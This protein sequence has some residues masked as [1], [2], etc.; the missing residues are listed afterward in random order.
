[1]NTIKMKTGVPALFYI[2]L[3]IFTLLSN[4]AQAADIT[5][6][7]SRNPVA[8]DDSFHLVYEANSSVDEDPDFT[9]IYQHFD[10]LS[11][12]QSTNM[13]SVNGSW[14]LQKT[15][16][17]SLIA[18]DIGKITVPAIK[19]G[20]DISPA[21]QITVV[22][23]S[24]ANS[25]SPD[26]QGTIPAQIFLESS[27]DKKS[28]WVQ[29]QFIYKVR[30]FRTVSI[31]SASISEPETSDPDA[32]IHP[33]GEDKYQTTRNGI[34]YEVFER[35]YAI[36]PQKS[37]PLKINPVTFE[38]RVNPT[39]ARSIFDR[40][41]IS[42]QLKRLRSK[43]V[44]TNVKSAPTT[45]NLQDWLPS[46]QLQLVEEWSDDINNIKAGDPITRTIT[47]AA[48]G[49]TA[50]QLP[51]LSFNDIDNLKQYPDKAAVEDRPTPSGITGLKQIKVALI[52]A[53]AGNYTL[54]EIKLEWWNTQ[55][56]KN[57]IA[58]LPP[59]TLTVTGTVTNMNHALP[60]T[61]KNEQPPKETVPAETVAT[62]TISSA[63][64]YWKWLSLF[65]AIAWAITL[66]LFFKRPNT[67]NK[68]TKSK[69][70]SNRVS[71]KAAASLV[72]QHAKT[73]NA[74]KTKNALIT[75]AQI[76]YSNKSITNLTLI[77]ELCSP[78]LAESIK[79]L[80]HDLYS[81]D[82]SSWHGSNLLTAFNNE[83]RSN[84]T[85]PDTHASPLKPL[86]NK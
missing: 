8:L 6:T 5:V 68:P 58:T 3:S 11:S 79:Q 56:N 9:P 15:W 26:D 31:A 33:L 38:G 63:A 17:L 66:I 57:E 51:D 1:M 80:N 65:F 34:R 50:V 84:N 42:G 40:F 13:R 83:Q 49:L 54:P 71:S 19:F 43:S 28:G 59:V 61:I 35:S 12:S 69:I 76:F 48:E 22:S 18:K 32:I 60:T 82:S 44:E 37:G 20:K 86:Y 2:L 7:A 55:S 77:T 78:Q 75:W 14:D 85:R 16:D 47:I 24:S 73:N 72:K 67:N 39:Q 74:N 25:V 27:I 21:I 52:P 4:V 46:S 10:V 41:R 64:S 81:T 36:F 30:L 53:T 23:S 62:P 45:I 29:S 70:D